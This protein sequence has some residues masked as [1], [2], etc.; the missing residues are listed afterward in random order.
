MVSTVR[1]LIAEDH[2]IFR[3]G[4]R[5]ALATDGIELVGEA[6]DGVTAVDLAEALRP[7]VIL[8]DLQMPLAGGIEATRTI[9]RRNP[10]VAVLVLTMTEDSDA[11]VAAV[12][13]V[14]RCY[15]LKGVERVD[16]L[17]A[18]RGVAGGEAI[19]GPGVADRLLY[20]FNAR[21][22]ASLPL[23]ALSDRERE[24]L[25]LVS[26]GYTNTAIARRRATKRK[27]LT[28]HVSTILAKR[29]GKDRQAAAQVARPT[30]PVTKTT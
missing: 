11:V 13:A 23:P 4:L 20:V 3:D 27:A 25:T 22:A 26:E 7:D 14:A 8:M 12:R 9:A 16:L 5:A 28:S 6:T 19:F 15:L 30:W 2:P 21:T 10:S 17:Q 18:I 24:V 29:Q 1:V